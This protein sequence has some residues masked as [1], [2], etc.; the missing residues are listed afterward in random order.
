M[1]K[2][3]VSA[4]VY[5]LP[6]E[7][8]HLAEIFLDHFRETE[9]PHDSTIVKY[10]SVLS[11]FAVRMNADK[12]GAA[13]LNAIAVQRFMSSCQNIRFHVSIPLR[14]FLSFLYDRSI[15]QTDLSIPLRQIKK[16]DTEKLPSIYSSDE[17]KLMEST[18]DRRTPKGK[19]D[20]AVFLLASRLGLRASDISSFQ[21][22]HIDWDR[23]LI[24]LEQVKTKKEIELPLLKVVGEAIV[25]YIRY[26]RPKNE[27]KHIFLSA[28][29]PYLDIDAG[30][31]CY[32][33]NSIIRKAG[34]YRTDRHAGAHSMRHS[35]A[36][37][38]LEQGESLPVIS[39]I[40]GHSQ[41]TSTM[42][43]LGVDIQGLMSCSL[44]VPPVPDNFYMQKG[45]VFY[46]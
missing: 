33:I 31:V 23:N 19:R 34:I 16:N 9:R 41:R 14:R 27:S 2:K 37:Q 11:R 17:I 5:P 22:G 43:Y 38:M 44:D 7:I 29:A 26:G 30:L 28:R 46:E 1:R 39:E 4:K 13:T 45:G 20:Y 18:I 3:R 8:G 6:G 42:V 40:L 25:D 36:T 15:I 10:R 35:L 21:F 24:R 32:I 12:V